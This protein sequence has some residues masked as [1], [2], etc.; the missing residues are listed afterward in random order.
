MVT[1][2]MIPLI[3]LLSV[4]ISYYAGTRTTQAKLDVAVIDETGGELFPYLE[5]AF[6]S[7]SVTLSLSEPAQQERLSG[8]VEEGELSGYL[9]LPRRTCRL[10]GS[11][12]TTSFPPTM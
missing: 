12:I 1:T 4:G 11:S 7:T 9:I 3:M 8:Q 5:S 10:G 2:L 6:S